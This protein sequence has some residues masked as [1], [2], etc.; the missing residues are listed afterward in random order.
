V[1]LW[2]LFVAGC[3]L[4]GFISALSQMDDPMVALS[5]QASLL[6]GIVYIGLLLHPLVTRRLEPRTP[7]WTGAMTILLTLVCVTYLTVLDG[8]LAGSSSLFEHLITPLVVLADFLLV[9][10]NQ[11]A[12]KWWYPI[13]WLGFPMA[14][15]GY[16]LAADLRLYDS[17]LDPDQS[18][19]PGV[20]AGFTLALLALGYLLF[21]Y[22]KLRRITT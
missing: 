10:R 22:G 7:W 6:A 12:T 15:L 8:S 4:Y 19:F 18:G 21:G 2:R 20:V 17:F 16:Y 14:Y 11:S 9:G 1:C 13:T 3:A 5:Q